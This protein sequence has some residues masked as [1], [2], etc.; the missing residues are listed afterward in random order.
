MW[1]HLSVDDYR[2]LSPS[3]TELAV[4]APSPNGYINDLFTKD[5]AAAL[6][7]Q[8]VAF[9]L[10][11]F[12]IAPDAFAAL[13]LECPKQDWSKSLDGRPEQSSWWPGQV[14]ARVFFQ[15]FSGLVQSPLRPRGPSVGIPH[16]RTHCGVL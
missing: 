8:L 11:A 4:S 13:D 2:C 3:L 12:A 1:C 6:P 10:R 5:C 14:T 9:D 7:R 16:P 15:F